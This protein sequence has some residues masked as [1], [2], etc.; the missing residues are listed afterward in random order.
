MHGAKN[1]NLGD[2]NEK[3]VNLGDFNAGIKH[4]LFVYKFGSHC[5]A[6]LMHRVFS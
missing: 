3:N 2:F 5:F 1:I 6:T 4:A